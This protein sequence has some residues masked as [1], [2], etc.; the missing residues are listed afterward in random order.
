ML[1]KVLEDVNGLL[2]FFRKVEMNE[3]KRLRKK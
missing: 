2:L 1:S 3:Q